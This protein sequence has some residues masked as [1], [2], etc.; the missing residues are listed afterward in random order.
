MS[1]VKL[2]ISYCQEPGV[3][4]KVLSLA[5]ELRRKGVDCDIDQYNPHP[6]DGWQVWMLKNV[7]KTTATIF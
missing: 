2:F 6:K 5:D 7:K 3:S 1:R 4:K